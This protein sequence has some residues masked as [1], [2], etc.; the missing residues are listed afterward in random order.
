[1]ILF[2]STYWS[3]TSTVIH[4]KARILTNKQINTNSNKLCAAILVPDKNIIIIIRVGPIHTCKLQ[5]IYPLSSCSLSL[6]LCAQYV[7]II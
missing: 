6:I 2:F 7:K 1:M 5:P 4:L 3:G